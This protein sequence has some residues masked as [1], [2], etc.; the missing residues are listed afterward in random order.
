MAPVGFIQNELDL[1]LLVLY[2]MA[3][4]AGPI[5]FLQLLELALCDAGVDYFSL[6]QA[7]DHMVETGQ[8]SKEDDRYTI[9]DKGRRNSEICQSSLP[10]SVRMHCDENLVKVNEALRREAQIQSRIEDNP[11]GTCTLHLGFHDVGSPLLE[12]SLLV[13][14]RPQAIAMS[15]QFQTNPSGIYHSMISLLSTPEPRKENVP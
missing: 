3:R 8:L 5:T 7:V 6:T 13:P 2:I 11:D 4:A 10:Y 9:T 14:G 15:H 12:L 1:K